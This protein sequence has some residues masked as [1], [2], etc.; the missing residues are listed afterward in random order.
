MADRGVAVKQ[1]CGKHGSLLRHR[2]DWLGDSGRPGSRPPAPVH[3]RT[4]RPLTSPHGPV[5]S[6]ALPP[7]RTAHRLTARSV[8]Q[9]PSSANPR[10]APK[11]HACDLIHTSDRRQSRRWAKRRHAPSPYTHVE[12]APATRKRK[13]LLLKSYKTKEQQSLGSSRQMGGAG[14]RH[15]RAAGL[16]T[17]TRAQSMA[18]P[19]LR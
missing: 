13:C 4:D 18:S 9:T 17:V 3:S 6:L 11:L 2:R 8:S 15:S 16:P 19:P 1:L 7:H 10:D 5:Y 12:R 14:R